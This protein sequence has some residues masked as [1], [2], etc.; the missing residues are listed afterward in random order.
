M[1]GESGESC[2]LTFYG[3]SFI[4]GPLG[5]KAAEAGRDDEAVLTAAF[6]LERIR[7]ARAAWGFFRDRRPELYTPLL[8]L[9]GAELGD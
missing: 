8:T 5:E 2:T 6:D 7:A 4:A 3:S 9:D 1:G